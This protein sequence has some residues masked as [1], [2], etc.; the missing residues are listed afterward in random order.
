MF[1]HLGQLSSQLASFHH[2]LLPLCQAPDSL[3][4]VLTGI[5]YQ[6]PA[7]FGSLGSEAAEPVFRVGSRQD[8]PGRVW[9]APS[10]ACRRFAARS[11][12]STS[13]RA[14]TGEE[15]VSFPP[16]C[17]RATPGSEIQATNSPAH[18]AVPVTCPRNVQSAP[19]SSGLVIQ[20]AA[21]RALSVVPA[22]VA[23]RL[24]RVGNGAP[25]SGTRAVPGHQAGE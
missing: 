13:I 6:V 19:G 18:H 2:P 9:A 4:W 14:P 23:P 25:R 12:T 22:G 17:L 8:G 24:L 15:K 21:R 7:R 10:T 20:T 16:S 1:F 11:V 5:I 3:P